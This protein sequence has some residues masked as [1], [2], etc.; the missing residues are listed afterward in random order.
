MHRSGV[1]PSV[2]PIFFLTLIGRAAHTQ[3]DSPGGSNR[4]DLTDRLKVSHFTR[5]RIGHFGDFLSSQSLGE[6]AVWRSGNTL[7]S[8][9]EVNLR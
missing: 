9:N 6:M 2:C 7:V 1:R 4:P 5:H 3:R 8:I